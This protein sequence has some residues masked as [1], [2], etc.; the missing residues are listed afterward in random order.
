MA[1]YDLFLDEN[2]WDIYYWVT[3]KP[4]SQET[5]GSSD[6]GSHGI[7]AGAQGAS[8]SSQSVSKVETDGWQQGQPRSGE[9]AQTVGTFKPAY[10]PVPARWENSEILAML[11][12]HVAERS[13]GGVQ[14]G[15][16][17]VGGTTLGQGV[18]G[19][20]GG[21]TYLPLTQL[22]YARR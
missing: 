5:V 15:R 9:W 3:Q 19:T 1:Q 16:A 20:G 7:T 21:G 22:L 13:A 4:P 12:Q 10:R 11:R 6:T 2:D 8:G 17:E 18:R 14:Q